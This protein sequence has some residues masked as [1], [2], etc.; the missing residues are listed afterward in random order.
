[1]PAHDASYENELHVPRQPVAGWPP[2]HPNITYDIAGRREGRRRPGAHADIDRRTATQYTAPGDITPNS[3]ASLAETLAYHSFS[4]RDLNH[5]SPTHRHRHHE[6]RWRRG[7]HPSE[8]VHGAETD[9]TYK[10]QPALD[11]GHQQRAGGREELH[12]DGLGR[13]IK[14]ETGYDT[15][16]VSSIAET[17][18]DSCACSPLGKVKRTSLPYA[19]G[20]TVYWTAYTYDALGSGRSHPAGQ[21]GHEHVRL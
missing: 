5:R 12:G 7:P 8:A 13:T 19:P 3:E 2:G 16:T 18:Y 9:Y 20:G 17:E 21:H 10:Q 6:L 15:T 4:G 1:M 11:Q 14:V